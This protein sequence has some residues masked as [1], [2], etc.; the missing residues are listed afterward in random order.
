MYGATEAAARLS[1]LEPICFSDK[2]ESIGKA[3]P[4]VELMVLNDQGEVAA[5]GEIG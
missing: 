1:Y 3:I 5:N 2:M 4:G